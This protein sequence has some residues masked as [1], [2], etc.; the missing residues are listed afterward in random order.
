MRKA[1]PYG[2]QSI[3][4]ADID[5]VIE[6]LQSDYLTTGPKV[7]EFEEKFAKYVGAEYAVAVSNGTAALHLACLALGLKEGQKVL[8]TPI[9]FAASSNCVLYCGAEIEFCDI[10]PE[11]YLIDIPALEAKLIKNP[12]SYAGIIPVDFTGL[13][14]DTEKL[15]ALANK[16][17][18]WIIEDACHAPGAY[19]IDSKAQKIMAGNGEY[20]ELT[21]FSFHPVKHIACGEGG[22]ITT[23]DQE[24][25]LS[26]KNLRTHG[27]RNYEL[28]ENHGGWYH[29][30]HDLGYNYRLPDINCA[31]GVTQLEKADEGL[32]RRFEIAHRYDLELADLDQVKIQKQLDN[33]QNAYH[34]Y[35]IEVPNRKAF[36]EF[37]R[38]KQIFAQVHYIPTHLHPFYRQKGWT[39]GDL[40]MSEHYYEHCISIPMYPGLSDDDQTYVID[41]I[42]QFFNG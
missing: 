33:T 14:V 2:R 30:M 31:L 38:E 28:E 25:Y 22:M 17:N 12:N 37:L 18:L 26:L 8:T 23:K 34:L 10:D 35:V 32:E 16:Y 11:T 1:I 39:L 19:F 41:C 3:D 20:S 7:A 29:E 36:Y 9:T 4:Q 13:P 6:T 5:A 42:H 24:L 27:I 40:P 15:R 21:C